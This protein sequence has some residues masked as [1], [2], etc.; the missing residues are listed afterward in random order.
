L[1]RRRDSALRFFGLDHNDAGALASAF[2]E[3]HKA[4]QR[5]KWSRTSLKCLGDG[6]PI[7]SCSASRQQNWSSSF[8]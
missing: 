4:A 7:F 5:L 8:Y 6:L 2:T 1:F 3:I